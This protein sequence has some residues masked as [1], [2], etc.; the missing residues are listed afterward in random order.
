MAEAAGSEEP[1]VEQPAA[2]GQT[3]QL[4]QNDQTEQAAVDEGKV[5]APQHATLGKNSPSVLNLREKS[6]PQVDGARGEW[7]A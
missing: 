5:L 2:G 4:E 3:D 6:P 1:V 7:G